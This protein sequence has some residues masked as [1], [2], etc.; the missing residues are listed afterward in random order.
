M[1]NLEQA[2]R[3]MIPLHKYACM[4]EQGDKRDIETFDDV[5][6]LVDTF[7]SKICV[8][9]LLGGIFNGVIGNNWPV[10]L[11]KMYRFW[12]TV[13]LGEQTYF[14]R[15]FP[16]HMQLPVDRLH[17]QTWLQVFYE[18]LDE[19]FEGEKA[20]EAKWR[21]SRMAEMFLTK[22]QYFRGQNPQNILA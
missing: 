1:R 20:E 7:Y 14:G 19:L 16:P 13:L 17:F 5:R 4:K 18:T 12:Q 11:D 10:H 9:P 21:S 22:I 8:H 2:A 3:W 15:P 6:L